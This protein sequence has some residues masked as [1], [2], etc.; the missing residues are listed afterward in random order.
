MLR[1][2]QKTCRPA[3]SAATLRTYFQIFG[4]EM[5]EDKYTHAPMMLQQLP[6]FPEVEAVKKT[7]RYQTMTIREAANLMPVIGEWKGSGRGA[8][9]ALSGRRGQIL[10]YAEKPGWPG[11]DEVEALVPEAELHDLIIELR[12]LTQGLGTFTRSFDHLAELNGAL[13]DKVVKA[14]DLQAA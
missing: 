5:Y 4:F 9:M 7:F 1:P 11:W 14:G 3:R 10:G 12:S 8:A 2:L 13:A 6:L